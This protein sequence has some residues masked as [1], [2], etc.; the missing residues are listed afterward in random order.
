M[1]WIWLVEGGLGDGSEKDVIEAAR[2]EWLKSRARVLRWSE[3]L[4]LVE[5]E[6]RRVQVSLS[7]KADWWE[8]RRGG[9]QP[10]A[11]EFL[12]G[13]AAYADK[14]AALIRRL[15]VSFS[16]LWGAQGDFDEDEWV[17]EEDAESDAPATRPQERHEF[18]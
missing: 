15:V 2:A 6:M 11:P 7:R 10:L 1:S 8:E 4:Q 18:D 9:W 14:Q 17:D 3:E 12:E 16:M 13:I 5:E